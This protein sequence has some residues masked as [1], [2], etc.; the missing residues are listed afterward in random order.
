MK[1]LNKGINL[2]IFSLNYRDPIFGAIILVILIAIVLFVN[3]VW[4][5]YKSKEEEYSIDKFMKKF[6]QYSGFDEYKQI[7]TKDNLPIESAILMA[8]TF[9]KGGEYEKAIEIYL[10]ILKNVKV[11]QKRKDILTLL[12]KTYFKAGFLE[13]SKDILYASLKIFPRN[14]E[15][16][17]YLTIIFEILREHKKALEVLDALEAMGLNVD[18]KKL[19][20]KTLHILH[21]NSLS[22]ET[23]LQKLQSLGIEN[24]I[25][26][27]KI[28]EFCSSNNM[29][30]NCKMLKEFDFQNIIDLI[31]NLDKD[32]IDLEFIKSNKIL[33]E[34]YSAKLG[35]NFATSSTNF[36]LDIL[37]TLQKQKNTNADL[38]F[39]YTCS[40]CKHTFPI[41]FYRCPKCKN[42]NTT[43]IRTII[44]K[45]AYETGSFI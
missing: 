26:Q 43:E 31:W 11:V 21:D 35:E 15:A 30:L 36:E 39:K 2:D 24:K 1:I 5:F 23:K 28:F 42:I 29:P 37:I 25:I 14:E 22:K 4:G 19:Y 10:A 3:Y 32:Q 18:D 44:I 27:R 6:D 13:K 40:K 12:G 34:I 33:S 16:L 9:E 7:I 8:L 17:T 41:Y 20:F 45:K 38:G